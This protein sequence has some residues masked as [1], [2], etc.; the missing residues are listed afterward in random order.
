MPRLIAPAH[1]FPSRPPPSV[2][3]QP[4][5]L[6]HGP[7]TEP[8]LVGELSTELQRLAEEGEGA[9]EVRV[10]ITHYTSNGTCFAHHM[11]AAAA[12]SGVSLR[13]EQATV[14]TIHPPA[15]LRR[16][17]CPPPTAGVVAAVE[18]E[19]EDRP[20]APPRLRKGG[21]K[22][23]HHSPTTTIPSEALAA[24]PAPQRAPKAPKTHNEAGG[25]SLDGDVMASFEEW[26]DDELVPLP[27]PQRA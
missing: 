19:E 25:A 24:A 27:D 7:D 18:A 11:R 21:A 6:L 14:L 9:A 26:F 23:R 22:G 13:T 16:A 8:H 17:P 2:I 3:G 15:L 4:L 12:T 20:I 10:C 1:P 5:S